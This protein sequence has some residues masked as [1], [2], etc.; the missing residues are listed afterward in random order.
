[1]TGRLL[2]HLPALFENGPGTK[3]RQHTNNWVH[4]LE[5]QHAVGNSPTSIL[6]AQFEGIERKTVHVSARVIEN[7]SRRQQT[8]R[9]RVIATLA[10]DGRG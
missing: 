5:A 10:A 3:S 9:V 8:V 7:A 2:T 4:R 1:M 6:A